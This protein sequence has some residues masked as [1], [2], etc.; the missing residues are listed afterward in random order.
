[1][2]RYDRARKK[3]KERLP[4]D[5]KSR[6]WICGIK[7]G[8]I[9]CSITLLF[10]VFILFVSGGGENQQSWNISNIPRGLWI[11]CAVVE[12]FTFFLNFSENWFEVE[13]SYYNRINYLQRLEDM[14]P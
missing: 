2:N 6:Q 13:K 11:F 14:D 1:M 8:V 12:L 3:T 9:N 10:V 5:I 7:E 4:K